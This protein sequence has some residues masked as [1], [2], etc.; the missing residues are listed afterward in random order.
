MRI[1]LDTNAFLHLAVKPDRLTRTQREAIDTAQSRYLSIASAWEIAVKV[2]IGKLPLP[3]QV[4]AYVRSRIAE[5]RILLLPIELEHVG[6]V[7]ELPMHHRDPFDRLIIA[8]ALHEKMA[9]VTLD[10]K[11]GAYG[12][13]LVS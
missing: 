5:L 9:L 7:Q 10:A 6:L 12:A 2:A 8:Q 4:S 11:L 3:M 1:L 13:P